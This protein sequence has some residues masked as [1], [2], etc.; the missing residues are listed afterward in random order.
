MTAPLSLRRLRE[1]AEKATP[2]P[3]TAWLREDY[4]AKRLLTYRQRTVIGK[5]DLG[6]WRV[7]GPY[8]K[9]RE[10]AELIA[11]L[12]PATVLRLVRIAALL[13]DAVHEMHSYGLLTN[14]PEETA[15]FPPTAGGQWKLC[16][17]V[18]CREA[19]AA[20]EGVTE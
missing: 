19:R 6:F 5:G 11:A 1:L 8:D 15:P 13:R 3:W 20:L 18:F 14:H 9:D 10:D 7:V 4:D 2:G 16:P 17:N 12:D